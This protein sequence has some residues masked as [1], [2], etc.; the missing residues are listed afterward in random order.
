MIYRN[1]GVGRP[2][3]PN[4]IPEITTMFPEQNLES[5]EIK[6]IHVGKTMP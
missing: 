3:K 1:S 4:G 6:Q 5:W 2:L